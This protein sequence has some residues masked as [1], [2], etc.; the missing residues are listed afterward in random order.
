[1]NYGRLFL[2]SFAGTIVFFLYGY[3][4]EGVLI[5]KD[6]VP[7]TAVY[8]SADAVKRYM[9]LGLISTLA[10]IFVLATIFAKTY[11][12]GA[13]AWQGATFGFSIGIFV[14]CIHSIT[15]LVVLNIGSKLGWEIAISTVIQWIIVGMVVGVIY[16]PAITST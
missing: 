5:R 16:R 7:Y 8:R 9:P 15:N 4:V 13:G 1:M 6:F 3:V 14:A 12:V 11:A 2:A 10:G